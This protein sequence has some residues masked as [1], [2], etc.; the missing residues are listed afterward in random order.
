M[1][2]I[3]FTTPTLQLTPLELKTPIIN[4]LLPYITNK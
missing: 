2:E 1:V 3:H 4:Y